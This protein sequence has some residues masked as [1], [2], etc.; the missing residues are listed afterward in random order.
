M[1]AF[2]GFVFV[3]CFVCVLFAI[4]NFVSLVGLASEK[5]DGGKIHKNHVMFNL[6]MK[7]NLLVVIFVVMSS[8]NMIIFHQKYMKNLSGQEYS[9]VLGELLLPMLIAFCSFALGCF[10]SWAT[11][12]LRD[13]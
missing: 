3:L 11:M 9:S 10:F 5:R 4:S 1:E 13:K 2:I 12:T 8:I 7:F 6:V